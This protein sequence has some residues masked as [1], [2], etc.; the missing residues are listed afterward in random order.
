MARGLSNYI[1]ALANKK[2][3]DTLR[4]WIPIDINFLS[5]Y[6]D[7]LAFGFVLLLTGKYFFLNLFIILRIGIFEVNH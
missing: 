7:F 1:D 6:P 2:I 5:P 4:E 3:R